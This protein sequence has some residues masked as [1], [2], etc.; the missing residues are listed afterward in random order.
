MQTNRE[1][2]D[3]QKV[4][5]FNQGQM[6]IYRHLSAASEPMLHLDELRFRRVC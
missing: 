1:P 2:T 4:D 6:L 3:S 5:H